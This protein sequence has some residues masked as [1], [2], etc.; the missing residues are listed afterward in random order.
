MSHALQF[1]TL[2]QLRALKAAGLIVVHDQPTMSMVK[3]GLSTGE[4]P[5]DRG[6]LS[7]IGSSAT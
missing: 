6:V 4:W 5:E 2:E 3:A 7:G 1:I